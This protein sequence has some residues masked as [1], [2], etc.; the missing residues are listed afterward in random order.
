MEDLVPLSPIDHLFTGRNAYPISFVFEY[1]SPLEPEALRRSLAAT[2]EDF[3]PVRSRLAALGDASWAFQPH[4]EGY[5]LVVERVEAPDCASIPPELPLVTQVETFPDEPLLRIRLTETAGGSLLGVSFSHAVVDGYSAFLFMTTWA[6]R[7]RGAAAI[8]PDHDRACLIPREL[9][10]RVNPLTPEE[11]RRRT[12]WEWSGPRAGADPGRERRL[13]PL[14]KA[15]LDQF[16]RDNDLS[17]GLGLSYNDVIVAH[18]YR[19][20]A[21]DARYLVCPYD[22]RRLHPELGP[23]YFGNAVVGVR[24]PVKPDL[25]LKELCNRVR[26][27]VRAVDL[28]YV[29]DSLLCLEELRRERG[30]GVA[31]ELAVVH[32][33]QGLLVTNL[34]R[35]PIKELDFGAG[36]PVGMRFLT[37]IPGTAVILPAPDGFQAQLA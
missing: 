1:G 17:I 23:G 21:P 24:V 29:Q 4:P 36:L 14:P 31:E 32:P 15:M 19:T 3:P 35:V 28:A 2:A 8:V 16:L 20:A 26:G 10:G 27:A 25:S 5:E 6:R 33:T 30:R 13:I 7:H 22:F 37:P 11:V 34:S 12:G 9:P 18:L